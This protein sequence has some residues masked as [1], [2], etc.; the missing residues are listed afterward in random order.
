VD[1]REWYSEFTLQV[2]NK[3]IGGGDKLS[4]VKTTDT[5]VLRS[6][7]VKLQQ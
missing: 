4:L 1:L 3:W 7:I 5:D 6:I 2:I